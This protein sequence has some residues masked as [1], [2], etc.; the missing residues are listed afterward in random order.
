MAAQTAREA[1]QHGLYGRYLHVII[2]Q[3]LQQ[4]VKEGL[5][6]RNVA[7]ATTPPTIRNKQMR[8]LSEDELLIFLDHA[9]KDR[10]YAAY[11]LA[12]TT[13]LRRGE[14][15][16]LCWDCVNLE[17]GT[18]A[19][20]R[21]LLTLKDGLSLEETTKSRSGKRSIT[22]PDDAIRE[23]KEY[24]RKQAEEKLLLGEAYQDHGLVF[25][26]EDGS[27]FDPRNFT[28]RFQYQ[29]EKAGIQKVRLHDLRHTHASL[30]L[31]RGVHPKVVQERMGHSSITITLDLYSHLAPGLE[32][33]AAA[34]LNGL[35][36]KEKSPAK[37]Q[38]E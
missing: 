28:K 37:A 8:P 26:N 33:A 19:I 13:G 25:C 7:D 38:G 32:E 14:L 17:H 16:G 30:L 11:V 24:K 18:I 4:A 20:Q 36:S 31:S 21:Q 23:L 10:L 3:A 34:S 1:S 29:L 2:H 35:L 9:K 6:A 22:L 27:M 15:L 5:L 12:V